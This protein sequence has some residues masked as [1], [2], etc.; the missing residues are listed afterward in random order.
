M[1]GV[2]V[3]TEPIVFS[4]FRKV[5][6]PLNISLDDEYQYKFVGQPFDKNMD[7][8]RRDFGVDIQTEDIRRRFNRMYE[9]IF[10]RTRINAQAGF[11]E[12]IHSARRRNIAT[13]LCTTSTQHHVEVIFE[14]IREQAPYPPEAIFQAVVT[15]DDVTHKKPHPEPYLTAARKIGA[16]PQSCL[17]IEDSLTGIRSA[18]AAGCFCIGLRHPYNE[19]YDFSPADVIVNNLNEALQVIRHQLLHELDH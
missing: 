2:F 8:I 17:V 15:G 5:F 18:K 19:Q 10:S 14:K 13:A 7:D 11:W 16:A 12:I 6:D 9:H 1:D 4:V 3:N